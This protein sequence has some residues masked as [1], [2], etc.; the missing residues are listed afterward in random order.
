MVASA[1]V[2]GTVPAAPQAIAAPDA[3]LADYVDAVLE[4]TGADVVPE[5]WCV[6]VAGE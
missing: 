2:P 1:T 4:A 6:A 5:L 3:P